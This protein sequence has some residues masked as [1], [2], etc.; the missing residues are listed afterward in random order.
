MPINSI[1]ELL[2]RKPPKK[3]SSKK[4]PSARRP[5]KRLSLSLREK[6]YRRYKPPPKTV[7][8]SPPPPI[9]SEVSKILSAAEYKQKKTNIINNK[10]QASE[11]E[12]ESSGDDYLVDPN[13]LDLGSSFFAEQKSQNSSEQR[14][15]VFDCNAGLHLTDSG[16]SDADLEDENKD[17]VE[18][19]SSEARS[20]VVQKINKSS[21][22]QIHDFRELH[23]FT[24]RMETAKHQLQNFK[25]A[26][27]PGTSSDEKIDVTKLLS[28][29]EGPSKDASPIKQKSSKKRKAGKETS[30]DSD[31]EDVQGKSKKT[32]KLTN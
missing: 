22:E 32:M 8:T 2:K 15:P 30:D 27:F 23:D 7:N 25:S 11:S 29:G 20:S 19:H 13:N 14:A 26:N 17:K 6:L 16:E 12:S 4:A 18:S 1:I 5:P 3:N 10:N 24:K 28:L 31:W 9:P 21:S